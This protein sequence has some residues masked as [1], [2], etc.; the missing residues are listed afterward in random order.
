MLTA[1]SKYVACG[2]DFILLD[3]RQETSLDFSQ[4]A[5]KLCCRR[6]GIGADGL[7]LLENSTR[8]QARMRI[9]N[10]DGSEA[11]MCGNGLRCFVHWLPSKGIGSEFFQVEVHGLIYEAHLRN[12][13]VSINMP[14][15]L[16]SLEENQLTFQEKE[17]STYFLD[18]GVPHLVVVGN[19]IEEI[20]LSS[21]APSLQKKE[22]WGLKGTNVNLM[23]PLGFSRLRLRTWERG[24]GETLACGTGALAAALVG[25][26]TYDMQLPITIETKS[27]RP[28]FLDLLDERS[29]SATLRGEAVF[30]YT[31][32]VNL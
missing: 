10:A 25:V 4:I 22:Q 26:K 14:F 3:H 21:W 8:A 17:Y 18:T 31:G 27:G 1:F 16:E 9:F 19:K 32:V 13:E 24:V 7:L 5:S 29:S 30:V 2:N 23:E 28:L 6:Y 12:Q 11:E 15:S 20:E